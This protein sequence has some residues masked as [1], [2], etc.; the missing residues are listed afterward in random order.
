MMTGFACC[1]DRRFLFERFDW[2]RPGSEQ[3]VTEEYDRRVV[4]S[5][6]PCLFHGPAARIPCITLIVH[7]QRDRHGVH[8]DGRGH[9]AAR[10]RVA[11]RG[12]S[13]DEPPSDD[14]GSSDDARR[15]EARRRRRGAGGDHHREDDARGERR[16]PSAFGGRVG[17]RRRRAS[18][19]VSRDLSSSRRRGRGRRARAG[20]ERRRRRRAERGDEAR[21]VG[22]G[23]VE[24]ARGDARSRGR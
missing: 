7:A 18:D 5:S 16:R 14:R 10:D 4:R 17:E 1:V 19:D 9:H 15:R 2:L 6:Q 21:A 11:R 3:T 22:Q 20:V 13:D 24:T 12:Q 8:G 23:A